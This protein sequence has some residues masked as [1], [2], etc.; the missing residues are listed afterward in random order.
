MPEFLILDA[1]LLRDAVVTRR[2][3]SDPK[4]AIESV[5]AAVQL[6]ERVAVI[7]ADAVKNV[8]VVD[9]AEEAPE[10]VS[11]APEA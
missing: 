5:P 8:I 10:V 9:P 1:A 2:A 7:R 11:R 4:S 3:T 6:P